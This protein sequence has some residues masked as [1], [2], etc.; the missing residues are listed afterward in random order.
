LKPLKALERVPRAPKLPPRKS[1]AWLNL[2]ERK[3]LRFTI[4]LLCE[5]YVLLL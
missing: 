1:D 3:L 5:M 4:D 2:A